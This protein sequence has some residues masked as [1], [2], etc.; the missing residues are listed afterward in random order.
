M[1]EAI[2]SV[3][4]MYS[5]CFVLVFVRV[6]RIAVV[7]ISMCCVA[8]VGRHFGSLVDGAKRSAGMVLGTLFVPVVAVVSIV[9]LVRLVAVVVL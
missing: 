9:V 7:M 3:V 1:C 6:V 8:M 4:G 5:I 2:G